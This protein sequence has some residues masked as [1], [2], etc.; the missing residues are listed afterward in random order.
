MKYQDID[1]F[2]FLDIDGVFNYFMWWDKPKHNKILYNVG[3]LESHFDPECVENFNYILDKVP[4]AMVILTTSWKSLTPNELK[5]YGDYPEGIATVMKNVGI[6]RIDGK[7][8]N[9][10][11]GKRDLEIVEFIDE[12][13]SNPY[14]FAIIDDDD[15]YSDSVHK[16]ELLPRFVQTDYYDLGLTKEKADEVIHLLSWRDE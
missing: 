10:F 12:Y 7:V 15:Y 5:P 9:N 13:S 2:I 3:Q 6:K 1:K 4:D 8:I 11:N 16:E 14:I